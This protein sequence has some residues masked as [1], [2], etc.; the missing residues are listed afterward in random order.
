MKKFISI[1]TA[2]ILVGIS[3]PAGLSQAADTSSNK[4]TIEYINGG[5]TTNYDNGNSTTGSIV[6]VKNPVPVYE[7]KD[8]TLVPTGQIAQAGT[9]WATGLS[10]STQDNQYYQISNNQFLKDS[11][12]DT[13]I[14]VYLL[15]HLN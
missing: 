1:I 10:V 6:N 12:N 5:S 4:E 8:G 2:V 14:S 9:K 3:V 15:V 13:D 11:P 7:I